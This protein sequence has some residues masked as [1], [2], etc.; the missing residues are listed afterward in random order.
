MSI[1]CFMDRPAIL[2]DTYQ[3]NNITNLP[4]GVWSTFWLRYPKKNYESCVID[5]EQVLSTLSGLEPK[6]N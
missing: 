4:S 1:I 6:E 3:M 5:V 2:E